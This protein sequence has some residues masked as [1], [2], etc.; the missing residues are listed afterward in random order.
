MSNNFVAKVWD[1]SA[2]AYT[3][4]YTAPDATD[5]T[6]GDVYLSDSINSDSGADSG[7]AATPKA[8]KTV[9]DRK[10]DMNSTSEQ[11]IAGPV[12]FKSDVTAENY[13]VGNLKGIA[14]KAVTLRDAQTFSLEDKSG[15]PI[16]P[17]VDFDGSADVK[18]VIDKLPISVLPDETLGHLEKVKNQSARYQLTADKVQNGDSVL[19]EDTGVMYLVVDSTKL[20]SESGYQAYQAST[21]AK[22]NVSDIGASTKPVYFKDGVPVACTSYADASVASAVRAKLAD[23]ALA[24][25]KL[26]KG[27][28][29]SGGTD[30]EYTIGSSTT[31]VYFSKGVPV[32]CTSYANATVK[33][34][35]TAT[36]ATT[37]SKL[38]NTLALGGDVTAIS[39]SLNTTAAITLSTTIGVGK[40]TTDKLADRAV[41]TNK[42][43]GSSVYTDKLANQSVT[44]EKLANASNST[45]A[46]GVTTAKIENGAVTLTKLD[47]SIGIVTSGSSAPATTLDG[48]YKL[49]GQTTNGAL[50]AVYIRI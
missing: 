20:T 45:T 23:A 10:L 22:L 40:V 15:D 19:E 47:T 1:A 29:G 2:G 5:K 25:T 48:R 30:E 44:T 21:A 42:L 32:A 35:A 14:E 36:A 11:V 18:F 8:V 49:Y 9:A 50:S 31:P 46:T 17:S 16:C 41:T 4:I 12:T 33:S 13:F 39:T 26:V 6:K 7:I 43:A 38:N 24:A 3:P 28:T 27:V 34:A 37:A